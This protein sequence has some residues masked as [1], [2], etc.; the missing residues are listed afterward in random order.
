MR[1][2]LVDPPGVQEG[3]NVG[4]GYLSSSLRAAGYDVVVLDLNNSRMPDGE[5]LKKIARYK[6]HVVGVSIKSS[7][8]F[9]SENI[10]GRIKEK[11]GDVFLV[12]GG[13]HVS[14]TGRD[15][16]SED[17]FFDYCVL[18]EGEESLP[19]LC[20]ALEGSERISLE[21]VVSRDD[22][23]ADDRPLF[24]SD[25]DLISPPEYGS[26]TNIGETLSKVRYPIV[27]SRGC[28]Y[29]CIYCS[30]CYISGRKWRVRS[31]TN[32]LEIGRAHV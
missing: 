22:S 4:L 26:F 31:L 12:G 24:V 13:P 15:F 21:G 16:L 25:L 11:F 29:E 23:K 30:V 17:H 2:L 27:T 7:T 3:L 5:W 8:Y 6:P 28:P 19:R 1:V 14:L 32:V 10:A 20:D 18:G 9:E